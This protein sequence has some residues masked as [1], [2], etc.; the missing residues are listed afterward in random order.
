MRQNWYRDR[1]FP[2]FPD[3]HS[4][5][6]HLVGVFDVRIVGDQT[7]FGRVCG[8]H[9]G[10]NRV[11][12]PFSIDFIYDMFDEPDLA[13]RVRTEV[14]NVDIN[15]PYKIETMVDGIRIHL[16]QTALAVVHLEIDGCGRV[17]PRRRQN[18]RSTTQ[19]EFEPPKLDAATP[20]DV[21]R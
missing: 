2:P 19:L 9:I 21:T 13:A 1:W 10:P 14:G 4:S 5:T 8:L 17:A 11:R 12:G 15:R 16:E 3:P 20:V 7:H 18:Y 6:L